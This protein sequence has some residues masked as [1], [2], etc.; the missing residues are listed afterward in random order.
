MDAK[1]E[2]KI[3]RKGLKER[4]AGLDGGYCRQADGAIFRQV[5]SLPEYIESQVLFCYVGMEGEID[6]RPVILD[7]LERGKQVCVPL[8]TARGVMEA[9]R[10]FGLGELKRGSFGILEPEPDAPFVSPEKIGLAL[11]P[12][13]SCTRD[14]RR[15]GY[16]GG[17]YDRFLPQTK[18]FRAVLCRERMMEDALP[19]EDHDERMDAVVTE[20]GA[21]RINVQER[22]PERRLCNEGKQETGYHNRKT[23]RKRR[24]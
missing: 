11:I 18:C 7:A 17:Y 21:Y 19:A 13:L 23:V 24:T 16:G 8:C 22:L 12:C 14:G 2:K 15:L 4:A 1:E 5:I 6:T 20:A 3:L 10:I 9:R